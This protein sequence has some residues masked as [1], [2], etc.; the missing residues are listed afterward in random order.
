MFCITAIAASLSNCETQVGGTKA[1]RR[2]GVSERMKAQGKCRGTIDKMCK[3]KG[4]KNEQ[5]LEEE[6]EFLP[7]RHL[8]V[9]DC[10]RAN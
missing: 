3:R 8:I 4:K 1:E 10:Q 2:Q 5:G 9:S 7:S 6:A